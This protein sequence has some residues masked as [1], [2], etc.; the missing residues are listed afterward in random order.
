MSDAVVAAGRLLALG[1]KLFPMDVKRLIAIL[2]Q[3][4]D[5]D[6]VALGVAVMEYER[7]GNDIIRCL[8]DKRAITEDKLL[9]IMSQV[10]GVPAVD[11]SRHRPALGLIEKLTA[12]VAD[13]HRAIP[14][15][16]EGPFL[17]VAFDNPEPSAIDAIRVHT[18]LNVRPH[19]AAP[20]LIDRSLAQYYGRMNVGGYAV[21]PRVTSGTFLSSDVVDLEVG[22]GSMSI[23]VDLSSFEDEPST[24]P[25]A[26]DSSW[27]EP[28]QRLIDSL[29]RAEQRIQLLEAHVARDEDVLRRL[30]GFII[31]KE[32]GSREEIEALL[33]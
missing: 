18:K 6:S 10:W 14:F 27:K 24:R 32:V 30:F 33:R 3:S 9:S 11:L 31:D 2:N 15:A 22:E 28:V 21:D 17:D 12:D 4:Q 1:S 25:V 26:S 13:T 8:L 29:S 23:P 19:V 16:E 5:V 20:R 7:W